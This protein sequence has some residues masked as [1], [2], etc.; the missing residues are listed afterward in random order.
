MENS[1]QETKARRFSHSSHSFGGWVNL[2]RETG[3]PSRNLLREAARN[4]PW[5]ALGASGM[6]LAARKL[7]R[8]RLGDSFFLTAPFHRTCDAGPKLRSPITC[9]VS[10]SF[11]KILEL[12]SRAG[13][14]KPVVRNQLTDIGRCEQV[15]YG[16]STRLWRRHNLRFTLYIHKLGRSF[17]YR[18]V[19]PEP[20]NQLLAKCLSPVYTRPS[21]SS[22]IRS[23]VSSLRPSATALTNC[24][25]I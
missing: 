9:H 11:P 2:G 18:V 4:L 6:W 25:N 17:Q 23:R 10:F 12:Q 8:S 13:W 5:E 14:L 1:P 24:S 15:E 3:E 21:A 19:V 16:T 20:I 7:N 22:L